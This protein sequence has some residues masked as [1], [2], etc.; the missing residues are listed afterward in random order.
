LKND[1]NRRS[2]EQKADYNQHANLLT[3]ANRKEKGFAGDVA[4]LKGKQAFS[5]NVDMVPAK[6]LDLNPIRFF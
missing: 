2:D 3:S 1:R 4:T 6:Q 5:Y